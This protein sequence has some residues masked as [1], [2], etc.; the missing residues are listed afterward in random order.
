MAGRIPPTRAKLVDERGLITAEWYRYFFGTES[1][2]QAGEVQ[3]GTGL[4]GGGPVAN[5]VEL[6]IADD[7]VG[8]EQLRDGLPCSVIGRFQNSSGDVADIQA[9]ANF[10]ILTRQGDQLVFAPLK[11]ES[12]AVADVPD[13]A[14]F[15]AGTIIY[16]TDEAGGPTLAASDG[17]DWLRT[18]DN[19]VIS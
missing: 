3:G 16:V 19:A 17:T 6:S 10:R 15:G 8:N 7:G 4:A 14:D 11:A 18:S 12:F 5:G 1:Q 2:V 9:T 13:A